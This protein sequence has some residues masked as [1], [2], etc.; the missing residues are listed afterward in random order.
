MEKV[1]A[2]VP[3]YNTEKYLDECISSISNQTYE[4]IEIILIDDGS[5]DNSPKICDMW[6]EKDSRIKVI[7]KKN[8]G[9]GK[10]RNKGI[11][12][13]TGK[14]IFF[15]DS[16]DYIDTALVEKC[17]NAI[18]GQDTAMVMYG[19]QNIDD[20][21]KAIDKMIPYSDKYIFNKKE[22]QEEFLP[23]FI[24]SNNKKRNF[25][26]AIMAQFYSLDVIK[27]TGW[28]FES[29]KEYIS[30]DFYSCLKLYKD[31]TKIVVFNEALYYYRHGHSS[32]SSSSRMT[33]YPM[34]RNYYNQCL[35]LCKECGYNDK[36][37]KNISEPYLSFTITCL[38]L[39]SLKQTAFVDKRKELNTILKDELLHKILKERNLADEKPL[40]R[41]L[42]KTILMKNYPL[43]RLLIYLQ[44]NKK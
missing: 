6:A 19:V 39:I 18:S 3:V 15:V 21:G 26:T 22:V 10:S 33:H 30:E 17:M 31:I 1:T 9:A 28:K 20:T 42:Y 2:V 14:Y 35:S 23:D 32:L 44:A 37:Q 5:H 38:K 29:E 4:N 12:I 41:I 25:S 34:I 8:E 16:D 36:V 24:F 11:E 43:V 13:A 27:K 7:H 40:K